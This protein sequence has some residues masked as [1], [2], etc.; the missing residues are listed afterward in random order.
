MTTN[1]ETVDLANYQIHKILVMAGADSMCIQHTTYICV[2]CINSREEEKHLE[3]KL[4]SST[5]QSAEQLIS[6]Y[7]VNV[8]NK[9]PSGH[10][11][12]ESPM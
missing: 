2:Y 8:G 3:R 7:C 5:P 10:Q 9:S 6:R 11:D 1:D 4:S 12:M